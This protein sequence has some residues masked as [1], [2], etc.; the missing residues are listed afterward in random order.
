M[1]SIELGEEPWPVAYHQGAGR[2]AYVRYGSSHH[3]ERCR[4]FET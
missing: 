1:D 2:A 3:V 4:R